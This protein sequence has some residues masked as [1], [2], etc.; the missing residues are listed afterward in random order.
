M[1]AASTICT[2]AAGTAAASTAYH[3]VRSKGARR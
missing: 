3:R 1:A 2:T